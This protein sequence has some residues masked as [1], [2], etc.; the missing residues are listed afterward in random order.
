MKKIFQKKKALSIWDNPATTCTF[1][2]IF[3]KKK[4][5]SIFSARI[6]YIY[7]YYIGDL[8][9]KKFEDIRNTPKTHIHTHTTKHWSVRNCKEHH[10]LGLKLPCFVR[11]VWILQRSLKHERHTSSIALWL[12]NWLTIWC[13]SCHNELLTVQEISFG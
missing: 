1:N 4:I 12:P 10:T 6:C 3:C 9:L 5:I 7:L 2:I 8:A 13:Q 11:W